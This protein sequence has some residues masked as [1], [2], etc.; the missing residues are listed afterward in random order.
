MS[1]VTLPDLFWFFY[2]IFLF[3][4]L[5]TTVISIIKRRSIKMS[6]L[7]FFLTLTIPIIS[8]I[9]SIGRLEGLNEFQHLIQE[10]QRGAAWSIYAF[11]G[12]LLLIIWWGLFISTVFKR[13]EKQRV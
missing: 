11:L 2:Y 10:L 13:E 6:I 8:L 12:Y 5:T 9:N 4:T 1:T 7:T 3:V